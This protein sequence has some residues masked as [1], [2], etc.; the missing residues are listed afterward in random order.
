MAMAH[1]VAGSKYIYESINSEQREIRLVP[2]LPSE[3]DGTVQCTLRKSRIDLE[4]SF[5]ELS[6]S[7]GDPKVTRSIMLDGHPF[8]VTINLQAA[9][10]SLRKSE[11]R[12]MWID[13][14][15]INQ[16]DW[17]ERA[18]QVLHLR[19]IYKLAK[20]VVAWLGEETERTKSAYQLCEELRGITNAEKQDG[21]NVPEDSIES[22]W[23]LSKE[24]QI[25][26]EQGC[27]ILDSVK[28]FWSDLMA[29]ACYP[30]IWTIR[31]RSDSRSL[32]PG[33]RH[34]TCL[35]IHRTL[36]DILPLDHIF[37]CLMQLRHN[38]SIRINTQRQP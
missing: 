24:F 9:L 19:A 33:C 14:I 11:P 1:S 34:F 18:A 8:K 23:K 10:R 27:S 28:N 38:H 26:L 20:R 37:L 32:C 29:R 21:T 5:K 2:I 6:Y 36:A 31:I 35:L 3:D 15:C 12:V 22:Q 13:A 17:A 16:A 25:K 4:P 7:W 30:S